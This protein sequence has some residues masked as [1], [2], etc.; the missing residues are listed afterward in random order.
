[1]GV[2]ERR[3]R[4]LVEATA[5]I[6]WNT[7]ASGEF[8]ADQPGWS[9]FTGQSFEQLRGWGWLEAVHPDD[10]PDTARVWSH[11]VEGRTLY[12]VEHRLRRRD[13]QYR[14]MSVR[15]VPLLADDGTLREWVGV[16]TDITE[17][18]RT[19]GALRQSRERL[20]AAMAASGTGTFR[21]D[22]RS[23]ALEWD[24][25]L[26]RL[27]GLGPDQTV[28]SL[29]QFLALIHP[30]DR[31]GVIRRCERCLSEGVDFAMEYRVVWPDGSVRWMDGRGKTFLDDRGEP[32]YMIG[33]CVDITERKRAEEELRES[34]ERL[35]AALSAS[36]TGTFRWDIRS[37]ALE[38]DEQL[39]RLFGLPPGQTLR[40]V[41]QFLALI[42]PEDRPGVVSRF[43]RCQGEGDDFAM[44]FRVVWPDGSIHWLDDRG[45]T[46]LDD[47]GEPLYM[48]GACV[49][50]TERKRAE[51][52]LAHQAT[53]DALT[54]MPNRTLLIGQ[55][56]RWIAS[57]RSAD[58][59]FA[60]LLLDLDR[61]K[62]INDTFG[63]HYGDAV[64]REMNP[65][66][67]E[68]VRESDMVARLG[69]DEFGILLPGEDR[70]GAVRVAERIIAGMERSIDV[71]GQGLEV[72]V[73]IGIALYP[74]HGRDAVTLMQPGR[75]RH[76]CGEEGPRRP[77]RLRGRL[78]SRQPGRHTA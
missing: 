17:R 55:I 32:L 70:A 49:D 27:F 61:F 42:H 67:R 6:V 30:E 14:D 48:T 4:S 13:G 15:A 59:P 12:Q 60:L 29:D 45:K 22:I 51:E 69:G 25:P 21:W 3:Y 19:E 24:E 43:E 26:K 68:A 8:E 20:M 75:R 63:H 71:E 35:V 64:L 77:G 34:R 52:R 39:D 76:V 44:E 7:P 23:G 56:E 46:F 18:V 66:L 40:S 78:R 36:G 74:E 41:E 9:D 50:I 65:R 47:R 37:G 53:H 73:S 31:P 54:G 10:R 2:G 58:T 16:H 11:A 72:G 5:A 57:A 1:M 62:E 38:W 33:A 28:A